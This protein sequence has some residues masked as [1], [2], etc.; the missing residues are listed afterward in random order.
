MREKKKRIKEKNPESPHDQPK[1]R[2]PSV[3]APSWITNVTRYCQTQQTVFPTY[4]LKPLAL[5]SSPPSN[6]SQHCAQ[7]PWQ[8]YFDTEISNCPHSPQSLPHTPSPHSS[9]YHYQ[10]SYG[11]LMDVSG[12]FIH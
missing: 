2:S 9:S 10:H 1:S 6:Q 3:S 7:T 8:D 11:C 5:H 4:S 12:G